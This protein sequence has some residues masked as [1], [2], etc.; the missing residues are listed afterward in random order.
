MKIEFKRENENEDAWNNKP[1]YRSE[2]ERAFLLTSI[3]SSQSYSLREKSSFHAF[4][5]M[6]RKKKKIFFRDCNPHTTLHDILLRHSACQLYIVLC[7]SLKN[8]LSTSTFASWLR[9]EKENRRDKNGKFVTRA[10]SFLFTLISHSQFISLLCRH[11][12]NVDW[13]KRERGWACC[14]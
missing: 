8:F 13:A 14:R 2:S 12:T 3:S 1:W 10:I 11:S 4:L 6:S 7:F 5:F 9:D